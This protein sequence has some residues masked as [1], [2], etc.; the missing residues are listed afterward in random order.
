MPSPI[1]DQ[2]GNT[3]L[4]YKSVQ[5]KHLFRD[6][7]V[8][9][10]KWNNVIGT[11]FWRRAHSL[12]FT[13]VSVLAWY[14]VFTDYVIRS[15]RSHYCMNDLETLYSGGGGGGA[16]DPNR[17]IAPYSVLR[18]LCTTLFIIGGDR[19]PSQRRRA[20]QS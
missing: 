15:L 13:A 6:I 11:V 7:V 4:I 14:A 18:V 8:L 19:I 5:E 2:T 1:L 9:A 10:R 17:A 20:Q 3:A 16:Q 12:D